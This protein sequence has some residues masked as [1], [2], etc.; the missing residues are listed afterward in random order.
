MKNKNL[1]I[2]D[3]DGVLLDSKSNMEVSWAY[4]MEQLNISTPFEDYFALIGRPFKDIMK[5]LKLMRKYDEIEK[6]YF[7]ASILG[8]KDAIFY[9][10]VKSVLMVLEKMGKTLAI[11]TSKDAERT[12]IIVDQMPV[13]FS[14]V[15]TPNDKLRGK[16]APDHLL[17]ILANLNFDP[18]EAVYIGDM[19]TDAEAARR[20]GID[21][22]H[23]EWGYGDK[24]FLYRNSIA[25]VSELINYL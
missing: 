8:L 20:A 24:N 9:E 1:I 19:A 23:A 22:I 12:Q 13:K 10:N 4:V 15:Q 5:H 17:Y 16:P 2:F 7:D 6:C 3:I 25:N 14:L 18:S 21:Y 11:A